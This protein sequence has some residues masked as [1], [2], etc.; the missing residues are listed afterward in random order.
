MSYFFFQFHVIYIFFIADLSLI[1]TF[2]SRKG[3]M[4]QK[5]WRRRRDKGRESKHNPSELLNHRYEVG[6]RL[7]V[8]VGNYNARN[9]F[10]KDTVQ[11]KK[12]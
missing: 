4:G 5:A 3:E 8:F 7:K 9:M 11:N 6:S 10:N 1:W 2:H 12:N